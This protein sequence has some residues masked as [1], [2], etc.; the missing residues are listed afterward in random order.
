MACQWRQ[1][2]LIVLACAALAY[3]AG[4]DHTIA[5]Q[6]CAN[7]ASECGATPDTDCTEYTSV[8]FTASA[9]D[10]VTSDSETVSLV[11]ASPNGLRAGNSDTCQAKELCQKTTPTTITV[12]T[13]AQE[14]RYTL[15]RLQDR[16]VPWAYYAE[17]D[18]PPSPATSCVAGNAGTYLANVYVENVSPSPVQGFSTFPGA[19]CTSQATFN[20]P[21]YPG[22]GFPPALR[23]ANE[24]CPGGLPCGFADACETCVQTR[25]A[26]INSKA[27]DYTARCD[28]QPLTSSSP[29]PVTRTAIESIGLVTNSSAYTGCTIYVIRPA[30]NS[31]AISVNVKTATEN[32][33]LAYE[34]TDGNTVCTD[35]N[36]EGVGVSVTGMGHLVDDWH[37][38][39]D[40]IPSGAKLVRCPRYLG[41]ALADVG[42]PV[43]CGGGDHNLWF[44]IPVQYA[45]N[46]GSGGNQYGG[47]AYSEVRG[48]TY[49][50]QNTDSDDCAD[51]IAQKAFVPGYATASGSLYGKTVGESDCTNLQ[52]DADNPSFDAD[53]VCYASVSLATMYNTIKRGQKDQWLLPGVFDGTLA[54]EIVDDDGFLVQRAVPTP[55]PVPE[56]PLDKAYTLRVDIAD[57]VMQYL[58]ETQNPINIPAPPLGYTCFFFDE[59]NSKAGQ[60]KVEVCNVGLG[61]GD[62]TK[63]VFDIDASCAGGVSITAN[64]EGTVPPASSPTPAPVPAP[65]AIPTPAPVPSPVSLGQPGMTKTPPLAVGDCFIQ[66]FVLQTNTSLL[67]Y[68]PAASNA[69]DDTDSVGGD[70]VLDPPVCTVTVTAPDAVPQA[71]TAVFAV[72]S[73][74]HNSGGGGVLSDPLFW[75]FIGGIIG[76]VLMVIGILWLE[77]SGTTTTQKKLDA[78]SGKLKQQ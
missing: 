70:N 76:F 60:L 62:T 49:N 10:G 72:C 63:L 7:L 78:V 17:I 13:T 29:P 25:Q 55:A 43:G 64:G 44:Y 57:T 45:Q 32:I 38:A 22:P 20:A 30:E 65:Q 11:S 14:R 61:N 51:P 73:P 9:A 68:E 71:T 53:E 31:L 35:A 36:S 1:L 50:W 8:F 3:C 18:T 6:P 21:P 59:S 19:F 41:D 33:T 77:R 2:A 23:Y 52:Q 12:T 34:H 28:C 46:Y 54:Y 48:L 15:T 75:G 37:H 58:A 69:T 24:Y 26:L 66:Y 27:S 67:V 74:I 56:S 5:H 4:I 42:A 40:T 39:P 47:Q 16:T